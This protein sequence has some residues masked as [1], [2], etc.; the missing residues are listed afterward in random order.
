MNGEVALHVLRE[1]L[2]TADRDKLVEKVQE[3]QAQR[4]NLVAA[5]PDTAPLRE[6]L[7]DALAEND[8]LTADVKD[9]RERAE[10]AEAR[11]QEIGEKP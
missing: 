4:D 3:A 10:R 9:W 8:S 5:I 2:L 11:L 6:F 7:K 1:K